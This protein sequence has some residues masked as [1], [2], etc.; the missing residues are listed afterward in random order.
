MRGHPTD[1]PLT[2]DAPKTHFNRNSFIF[3]V[4][5]TTGP[6]KALIE[7]MLHKV[8]SPVYRASTAD[9]CCPSKNPKSF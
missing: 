3:V 5:G 2:T 7:Q 1:N 6:G 9:N 4:G 8:S